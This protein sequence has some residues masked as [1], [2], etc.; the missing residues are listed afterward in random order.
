MRYSASTRRIVTTGLARTVA[1]LG[2][3]TAVV[4]IAAWTVA[5][6]PTAGPAGSARGP[7][8]GVSAPAT[9]DGP[10]E[11]RGRLPNFYRH[12]VTPEQRDQM[13]AIMDKYEAQ[14]A[15]LQK[16]IDAIEARRDAEVEA[17]LTPEQRAKLVRVKEFFNQERTADKEADRSKDAARDK[18]A[19]AVAEGTDPAATAQATDA[20]K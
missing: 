20:G 2:L 10:A 16:Q 18:A 9:K 19:A 4:G 15:D 1:R 7:A 5:Q 17:M 14:I 8:P 6:P 11:Q 3:A 12:V 13:Y